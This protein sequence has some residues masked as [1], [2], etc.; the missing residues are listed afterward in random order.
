MLSEVHQE[1]EASMRMQGDHNK[2]FD[3]VRVKYINLDSIKSELFTNEEPTTNGP[4]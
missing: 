4:K 2:S 3:V 1:D